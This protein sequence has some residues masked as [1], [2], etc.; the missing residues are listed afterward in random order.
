MILAVHAAIHWAYKYT[1][2]PNNY[3]SDKDNNSKANNVSSKQIKGCYHAL[4]YVSL[5]RSF[6]TNEKNK[7]KSS[8]ECMYI[9]FIKIRGMKLYQILGFK[10]DRYNSPPLY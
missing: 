1:R 10:V 7:N 2:M 4:N 8:V 6:A 9:L 5:F 3:Q